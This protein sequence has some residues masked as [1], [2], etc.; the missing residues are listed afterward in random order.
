M[1][2]L[3]VLHKA[4][5]VVGVEV[6]FVVTVGEHEEVQVPAGRHHLVEGAELFEAQR[7]LVII[8]VCLLRNDK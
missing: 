3:L 1:Y 7:P 8:C 4:S 2:L 6:V 5:Q